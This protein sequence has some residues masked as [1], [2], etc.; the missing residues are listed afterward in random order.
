MKLKTNSFLVFLQGEGPSQLATGSIITFVFL[1]LNLSLRPYCTDGLNN[2]QTFS[3]VAQFAT[4]FCGIL[5]G[6][7]QKSNSDSIGNTD[8]GDKTNASVMGSTIVIIN[9]ATLMW[10]LVRKLLT[11]KVEEYLKH[12][13][14][15]LLLPLQ[16]WNA[17]C[18]GNTRAAAA[19]KKDED[20]RTI[21]R[22]VAKEER[23]CLQR[24]GAASDFQGIPDDQNQTW[25]RYSSL[26][27][28][29]PIDDSAAG[30]RPDEGARC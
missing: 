12:G 2:L 8:A 10:P 19:R 30:T 22:N 17:F 21:R 27:I 13:K 11:G 29:T 7:T 4:L 15:F 6:Y 23:N 24:A 28:N 3:L 9:S 14:W 5:I 25:R 18:G 1:L 26:E 20:A 16:F